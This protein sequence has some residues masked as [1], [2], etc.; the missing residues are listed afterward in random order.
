MT[1]NKS[2]RTAVK[3][4]GAGELI[5]AAFCMNLNSQAGGIFN[6]L[7]YIFFKQIKLKYLYYLYY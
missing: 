3:M 1:V 2:R 4:V 7:M 6:I 5:Q